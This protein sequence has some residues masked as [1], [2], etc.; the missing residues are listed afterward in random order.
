MPKRPQVTDTKNRRARP[1]GTASGRSAAQ[2]GGVTMTNYPV[3]LRLI[4]EDLA[5]YLFSLVYSW[6]PRST[7]VRD[8]SA[9]CFYSD[10]SAPAALTA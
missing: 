8:Q 9:P 5:R 2:A 4:K 1:D 3:L 10:S 6:E 7:M